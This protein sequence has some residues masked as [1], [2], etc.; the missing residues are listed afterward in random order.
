MARVFIG[1]PVAGGFTPQMVGSLL[2]LTQQNPGGHQLRFVTLHN[3]SLISR[4]RNR[5][6]T[7][8]LESGDDVLVM[9]D[10]DLEFPPDAIDRLI[11]HDRDFVGAP[12]TIKGTPPMWTVRFLPGAMP[13]YV[14]GLMP[15][16]YLPGGFVCIKRAVIERMCTADRRY[17][18]RG[19]WIYN[20]FQPYVTTLDGETPEYLPED[21]AFC[22]RAREA[23]YELFCDFDLRLTHWGVQGY[24]MVEVNGRLPANPMM[25]FMDGLASMTDTVEQLA[26]VAPTA[27]P[28]GDLSHLLSGMMASFA[29]VQGMLNEMATGKLPPSDPGS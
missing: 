23:G 5:L 3:E 10:S 22:E 26:A 8:F 6:A 16:Q 25:P 15:V 28:D 11:R 24:S 21:W 14:A 18:Q 2:T 7:M 17:M 13:T 4:G 27:T 1:L 12:Y 9:I 29:E 20:L 19:E